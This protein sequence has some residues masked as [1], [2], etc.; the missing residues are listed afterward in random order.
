VRR[1]PLQERQRARPPSFLN[2]QQGKRQDCRETRQNQR[3]PC[4]GKFVLQLGLIAA[5]EARDRDDLSEDEKTPIG[6]GSDRVR[7]ADVRGKS[8]FDKSNKET[9][10]SDVFS[11]LLIG[12]GLKRI[13]SK[14]SSR[15]EVRALVYG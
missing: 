9:A 6:R 10:L 7:Q 15:D 13:G 3:I 8:S 14:K 5:S 11:A 1:G 4:S 2:N 12:I